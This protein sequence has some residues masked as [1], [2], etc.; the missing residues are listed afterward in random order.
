VT[1]DRDSKERTPS[2]IR[3]DVIRWQ[4]RTL[5]EIFSIY[6]QHGVM[7]TPDKAIEEFDL[8]LDK[9]SEVL[10]SEVSPVMSARFDPKTIRRK[11]HHYAVDLYYRA[12]GSTGTTGTAVARR[13][14]PPLSDAH[15]DQILKLVREGKSVAEI[16]RLLGLEGHGAKDR[17]RHRIRTAVKRWNQA[18]NR[19]HKLH[20]A[21]TAR[22]ENDE[23]NAVKAE[24]IADPDGAGSSN[25][26]ETQSKSAVKIKTE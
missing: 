4:E 17:M 10:G 5:E 16:A 23:S 1:E 18:V 26:D 20:A 11:A 22:K 8:L 12:L 2:E 13:G 19:I 6:Q 9:L 24:A 21:Q 14:A 25:S 7:L 3:N 15:V